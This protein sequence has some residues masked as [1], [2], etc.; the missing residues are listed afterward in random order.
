M[1]GGECMTGRMRRFYF[2]VGLIVLL[3]L[4]LAI[5]VAG[6]RAAPADRLPPAPDRLAP[7][8]VAADRAVAVAARK[9]FHHI[10]MDSIRHYPVVDAVPLVGGL[11]AH[12]PG[13]GQAG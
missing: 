8:Q 11:G 4:T 2:A 13:F 3:L 10:R 5:L 7:D 9:R 12:H 6:F 1:T